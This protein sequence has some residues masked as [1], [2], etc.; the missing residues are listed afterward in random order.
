MYVCVCVSESD[1]YV[2]IRIEDGAPC[3]LCYICGCAS[4]C[5]YVCVRMDVVACHLQEI[6]VFGC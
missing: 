5:V 2:Y 6:Y 3:L 4:L 1:M